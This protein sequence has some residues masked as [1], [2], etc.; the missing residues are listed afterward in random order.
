MRITQDL[1]AEAERMAGLEEKSREFREKGAE[2][3]V[4]EPAGD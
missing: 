3:Y 2:L 1:R 4:P